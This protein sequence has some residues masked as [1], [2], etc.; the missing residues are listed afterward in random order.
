VIELRLDYS[1]LYQK[2]VLY[3][4]KTENEFIGPKRKLVGRVVWE[5]LDPMGKVEPDITLEQEQLQ[6]LFDKMYRAGLR[7]TNAAAIDG[8]VVAKD[9][10]ITH[11]HQIVVALLPEKHVHNQTS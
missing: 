6:E 2:Y 8:I 4:I 10:H 1:P 3:P 7:P 11:L 5:P 9:L